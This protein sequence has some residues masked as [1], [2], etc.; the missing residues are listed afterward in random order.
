MTA[1]HRKTNPQADGK[2]KGMMVEGEELCS[3]T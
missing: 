3:G 2:V 1:L